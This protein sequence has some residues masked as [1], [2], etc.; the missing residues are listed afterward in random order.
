MR[1]TTHLSD[2]PIILTKTN[3]SRRILNKKDWQNKTFVKLEI[4]IEQI[5]SPSLEKNKNT[6]LYVGRFIAWKGIKIILEA[7]YLFWNKNKDAQLILIGEGPLQSQIELFR[8]QHNLEE[9]IKIIPWLIQ[10]EL[11]QYYQSSQALLFPSLHD[12]SGNVVLEALA[13]GLPVITLDCGGPACVLGETLKDMIVSTHKATIDNVVEGIMAKMQQISS[14][15][16]FYNH[17][18]NLSL[19]R[20]KDFLWSETVESTYSFIENRIAKT[21]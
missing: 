21:S 5:S 20:A 12:S 19:E 11:K 9:H 17:I 4:G 14:D 1:K 15:Q 6:F 8:K 18:Q 3:D 16:T 10:Q 7:F 2:E 13:N